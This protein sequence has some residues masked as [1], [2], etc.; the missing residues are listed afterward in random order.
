M[1]I[2][3]VVVHALFGDNDWDKRK[4]VITMIGKLVGEPLIIDEIHK[5]RI[6]QMN[7]AKSAVLEKKQLEWALVVE[8]GTCKAM[9]DEWLPL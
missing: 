3:G 2:L 9:T 6:V 5:S 1:W 7:V 8:M 4:H